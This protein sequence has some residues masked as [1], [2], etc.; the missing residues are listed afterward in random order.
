MFVERNQRTLDRIFDIVTTGYDSCTHTAVVAD[1]Q[2]VQ[3]KKERP[4]GLR[5]HRRLAP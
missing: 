2:A 3:T 5:R 4:R 1:Q